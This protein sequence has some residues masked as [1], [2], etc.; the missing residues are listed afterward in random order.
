MYP[1][2]HTC[3]RLN[4]LTIASDFPNVT[5]GIMAGLGADSTTSWHCY[6]TR[7]HMVLHLQ[8][9]YSQMSRIYL[10]EQSFPSPRDFTGL[11]EALGFLQ[12][13]IVF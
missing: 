9:S 10:G 12:N 1:L 8:S 11:K 4:G 2:I 13:R 5:E 3:G 7:E 6:Y